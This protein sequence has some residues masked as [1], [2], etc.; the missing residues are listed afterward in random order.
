MSTQMNTTCS[1]KS[2]TRLR[3]GQLWVSLIVTCRKFSFHTIF[4][5][6]LKSSRTLIEPLTVCRF[7]CIAAHGG[8]KKSRATGTVVCLE[9]IASDFQSRKLPDELNLRHRYFT[10]WKWSNLFI[11]GT[12]RCRYNKRQPNYLL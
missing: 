7:L 6:C 1:I 4:E 10:V 11:H 2:E 12:Y 9:C 3:I 5:I 8:W